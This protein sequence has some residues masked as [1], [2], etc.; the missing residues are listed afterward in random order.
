MNTLHTLGYRADEKG[1]AS[2]V[3]LVRHPDGSTTW[4]CEGESPIEAA[5][6][7]LQ[8]TQKKERKNGRRS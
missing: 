1:A 5:L 8:N 4:V 6:L 3:A 2:V 7:L